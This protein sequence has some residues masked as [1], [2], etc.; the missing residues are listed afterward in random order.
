VGDGTLAGLRG[1]RVA[2]T[3]GYALQEYLR[4]SHPGIQVV[5]EPDDLT[6]LT[7]TAFGRVDAAIVNL[8]VASYLIEKQGISNLRVAA[9]SGRGNP[10]AIATRSDQPLL[11]SIMTKGLAAVT[12]E[13]REAI[14]RRWIHMEGVDR[15]VS[16]RTLAIWAAS[17]LGALSLAGLLALAWGRALRRQVA[18]ATTDLQHELAERRRVESALRR[19]EGKLAFHL[20]QTVVGVWSSTWATGWRTGTPLPSVS[21]GGSARRSWDGRPPSWFPRRPAPRSRRSGAPCAPVPADGTA[22]TPT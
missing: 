17:V 12:P 13:E 3:N 20:D 5:P 9:D 11:R 2:V 18:K 21:S 10:L 19:S 22:S 4:S 6:C 16:G 14:R 15:F 8:A 7:E 1:R